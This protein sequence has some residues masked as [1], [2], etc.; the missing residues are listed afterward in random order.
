MLRII[1]MHHD[2]MQS[3]MQQTPNINPE[4]KL[5]FNTRNCSTSAA[6]ASSRDNRVYLLRV[7]AVYWGQV[8]GGGGGVVLRVGFALRE[9][10]AVAAL[11]QHLKGT[12][13]VSRDTRHVT[14]DVV[15]DTQ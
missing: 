12:W 10:D 13:R 4:P 15:H 8:R 5:T 14:W 11:K 6:A 9:R 2:A 3:T 7:R 1:A